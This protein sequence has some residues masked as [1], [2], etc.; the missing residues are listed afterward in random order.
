MFINQISYLYFNQLGIEKFAKSAL[1][2]RY[3][4]PQLIEPALAALGQCLVAYLY[5]ND[6]QIEL[7]G[8]IERVMSVIIKWLPGNVS[9]EGY[10]RGVAIVVTGVLSKVSNDISDVVASRV[11]EVFAALLKNQ[12]Q[13]TSIVYILT[14]GFSDWVI[15]PSSFEDYDTYY[16]F[17][18][19]A[20]NNKVKKTK[21]VCT[22]YL[23]LVNTYITN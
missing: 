20:N 22:V 6:F 15:N 5:G 7:Y 9:N 11:L 21:I 18:D 4:H 16:I 3:E 8:I 19:D 12:K 14:Q 1:Q 2:P 23:L 13:S 17:L 10:M